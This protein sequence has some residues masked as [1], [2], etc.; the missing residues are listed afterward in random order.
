[1]IKS[2]LRMLSISLCVR[3]FCIFS[4]TH[5]HTYIQYTHTHHR[6]KSLSSHYYPAKI[7]RVHKNDTY[8]VDFDDGDKENCKK[9]EDIFKYIP[10]TSIS[11][12]TWQYEM[13]TDEWEEFNEKD[14]ARIWKFYY[15]SKESTFSQF[16]NFD[17]CVSIGTVN[18]NILDP[19]NEKC[20][21][22]IPNSRVSRVRLACPQILIKN[23]INSS[24]LQKNESTVPSRALLLNSTSNKVDMY[25]RDLWRSR[26]MIVTHGSIVRD[27]VTFTQEKVNINKKKDYI[28]SHRHVLSVLP[29]RRLDYS[30]YPSS[31]PSISPTITKTEEETTNLDLHLR[32][33]WNLRVIIGQIAAVPLLRPKQE[34]STD[35]S[36]S[37]KDKKLFSPFQSIRKLFRRK[38]KS[39]NKNNDNEN[40]RRQRIL[41]SLMRR[42]EDLAQIRKPLVDLQEVIASR[43]FLHQE[44]CEK[45]TQ[46]DF[47]S[48]LEIQKRR[49][50]VTKLAQ[51]MLEMNR[52]YIEAALRPA[53]P[54]DV[55]AQMLKNRSVRNL[56]EFVALSLCFFLSHTQNT[57]SSRFTRLIHGFDTN[58]QTNTHTHT[59]VQIK[60]RLGPNNLNGDVVSACTISLYPLQGW[61]HSTSTQEG[62]KWVANFQGTNI[63][64]SASAPLLL[65]LQRYGMI[66]DSI[67][68]VCSVV[69]ALDSM[70]KKKDCLVA[71]Q[72]FDENRP[73]YESIIQVEALSKYPALVAVVTSH[74]AGG[75]LDVAISKSRKKYFV[76]EEKKYT[77]RKHA[78]LL[79]PPKPILIGTVSRKSRPSVRDL[80]LSLSALLSLLLC[81]SHTHT[82]TP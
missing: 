46:E 30:E 40:P 37:R 81:L 28:D 64:N 44:M 10:K 48:C 34:Q 25:V 62:G 2:G 71:T 29:L 70:N 74:A 39:E 68:P 45:A 12:W 73:Y 27:F 21:V 75:V 53:P 57:H 8:D 67:V 60:W 42:A 32:Q 77:F 47:T 1:V 41:S 6:F 79:S 51:K 16:K 58:K 43:A 63:C 66:Q 61:I 56:F 13:S 55:R 14:Q 72:K 11:C 52:A 7:V 82:H 35:S 54:V 26:D 50:E 24:E 22:I 80:S 33:L 23:K 49:D 31:S 65:S 78:T 36:E 69:V 18:I 15:S 38:S 4:H 3:V 59:Q 9:R 76:T 19:S 17:V 20:H 5:I